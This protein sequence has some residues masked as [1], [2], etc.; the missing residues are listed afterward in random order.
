MTTVTAQDL[1]IRP[2]M[3]EARKN[4]PLG[5]RLFTSLLNYSVTGQTRQVNI[6]LNLAHQGRREEVLAYLLAMLPC[7][8]NEDTFLFEAL[9]VPIN[10]E[11]PDMAKGE[12]AFDEWVN[13]YYDASAVAE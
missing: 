6:D 3:L 1:H 10:W 2:F 5:V 12:N 13:K 4:H 7:P 9:P 8:Y 11:L